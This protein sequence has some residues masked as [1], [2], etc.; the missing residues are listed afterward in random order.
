MEPPENE[1]E[2]RRR[3]RS[4]ANVLIWVVIG[5]VAVVGAVVVET[6][7]LSSSSELSPEEN[8]ATVAGVAYADALFSDDVATAYD[9]TCAKIH[10]DMTLAEFDK[11]QEG[12]STVS[13][14]ELIDVR[15]SSSNGQLSGVLETQMFLTD[16]RVFNQ[17]IPLAKEAGGW[18]ACE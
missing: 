4:R 5:V 12:R 13:R 18:K 2:P 17:N 8:A 6:R 11:Y 14:Y 9:L 10:Q 15:V 16:G 3:R 1:E 7:L